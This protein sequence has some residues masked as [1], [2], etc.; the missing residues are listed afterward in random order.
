[1][2]GVV[3]EEVGVANFVLA[4]GAI[5]DAGYHDFRSSGRNDQEFHWHEN[6]FELRLVLAT[7]CKSKGSRRLS[8]VNN[9]QIS[10]MKKSPT[11][12]TWFDCHVCS[13]GSDAIV[14]GE[15]H[16]WFVQYG[17]TDV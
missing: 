14:I 12:A 2:K 11:S 9:L 5:G 7:P 13:C 1:M 17:E 10:C 15:K 6:V 3:G 4:V 16:F 8:S